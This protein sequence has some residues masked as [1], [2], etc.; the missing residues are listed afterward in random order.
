MLTYGYIYIYIYS[1]EP[2]TIRVTFSELEEKIKLFI[3]YM[4]MSDI[5]DRQIYAYFYIPTWTILLPY[6][7][8]LISFMWN[9]NCCYI[10]TESWVW[11]IAKSCRNQNKQCCV[12]DYIHVLLNLNTGSITDKVIHVILLLMKTCSFFYLNLHTRIYRES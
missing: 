12:F 7:I 11:W 1:I 10:M 8:Y 2:L 6:L 9:S 3:I 4:Y 5:K